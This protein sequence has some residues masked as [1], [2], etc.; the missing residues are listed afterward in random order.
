MTFAAIAM[1]VVSLALAR[2]ALD[3]SSW[4]WLLTFSIV[5][6]IVGVCLTVMAERRRARFSDAA[7]VV[8]LATPVVWLLIVIGYGMQL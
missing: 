1:F 4:A 8:L 3:G 7:V 6:F 2:E 5:A